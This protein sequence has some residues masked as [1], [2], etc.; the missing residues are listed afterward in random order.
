MQRAA[1]MPAFLILLVQPFII[2]LPKFM[3]IPFTPLAH[4]KRLAFFN[5]QDG[6]EKQV[7]IVIHPLKICLS[8]TAYGAESWLVIKGFY[9]GRNTGNQ[10]THKLF[11]WNPRRSRPQP[12]HGNFTSLGYY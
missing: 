2:F 4:D 12:E 1:A 9:F 8:Q 7:E 6:N 11:L 10:K 5:S 3:N